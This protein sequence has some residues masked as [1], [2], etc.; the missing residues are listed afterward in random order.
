MPMVVQAVKLLVGPYVCIATELEAINVGIFLTSLMQLY[1]RWLV[2]CLNNSSS[3]LFPCEG[4]L[5][6]QS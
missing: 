2:R 6:Y 1:Q 3:P 4:G 5:V